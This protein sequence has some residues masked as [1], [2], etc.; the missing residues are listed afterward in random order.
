LASPETLLC[1]AIGAGLSVVAA[2]V[3][4]P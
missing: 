4:A 2:W 1:T 3:R